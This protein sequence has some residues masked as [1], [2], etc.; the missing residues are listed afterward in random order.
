[1]SRKLTGPSLA[2][3]RFFPFHL[4][5]AEKKRAGRSTQ[6]ARKIPKEQ[7]KKNSHS[8]A[9][10]QIFDF[11]AAEGFACFTV[12]KMM[13]GAHVLVAMIPFFL[14]LPLLTSA[15]LP[16]PES[17]W[18]ATVKFRA[19]D[20]D[21]SCNVADATTAFIRRPG[22][23][24]CNPT[25]SGNP[26]GATGWH[27]SCV[28][29]GW[30]VSWYNSASCDGSPFDLDTLTTPTCT[31][32][33][34]GEAE[35]FFCLNEL[36]VD[37]VASVIGSFDVRFALFRDDQCTDDEFFMFVYQKPLVCN[38]NG[39]GTSESYTPA[40]DGLS[41][42]LA[43]FA[44]E[45]CAGSPAFTADADLTLCFP[46]VTVADVP[47]AYARA[48]QFVGAPSSSDKLAFN[49]LMLLLTALRLF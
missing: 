11:K 47:V 17:N 26:N 6:L 15:A 48:L 22:L 31:G 3:P 9:C 20:Q 49:L 28:G 35:E 7:K 37:D 1:M 43:V 2:R 24:G 4:P 32:N 19:V 12:R 46:Y 8:F 16:E 38:V 39:D 30:N 34:K 14:T 36:E 42:T 45:N 5:A 29:S 33:D 41:G 21:G 18:P 27:A 40:V 13:G 23:E 44:N 25:P 10:V